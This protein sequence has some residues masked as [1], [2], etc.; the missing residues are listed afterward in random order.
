MPPKDALM[1]FI[2]I[3]KTQ[4]KAKK[5]NTLMFDNPHDI[6]NKADSQV[7]MELNRILLNKYRN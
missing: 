1:S 3:I 6:R 5:C 2:D 7:I 4:L